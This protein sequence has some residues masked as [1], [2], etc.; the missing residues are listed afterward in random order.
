[1]YPSRAY[2]G[3]SFPPSILRFR[4]VVLAQVPQRCVFSSHK[5]WESA[6]GSL[7]CILHMGGVFPNIGGGNL[8]IRESYYLGVDIQ[9][10]LFS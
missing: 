4:P 7:H 6:V 9:G 1:M 8:I 5:A 10:P 2:I 3:S